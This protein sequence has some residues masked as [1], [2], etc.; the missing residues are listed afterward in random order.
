MDLRLLDHVIVIKVSLSKLFFVW[1]IKC[2]SNKITVSWQKWTQEMVRGCYNLIRQ[3][4]PQRCRG[5]VLDA[6]MPGN[7]HAKRCCRKGF[8]SSQDMFPNKH[9]ENW[10]CLQYLY[11]KSLASL[12]FNCLF[13]LKQI[14]FF[15]IDF[16][17]PFCIATI[18]F[19]FHKTN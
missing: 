12:I 4:M 6:A 8:K 16:F 1:W 10:Y 15:E 17:F 9:A 13:F 14:L 18:A 5:E 11:I 19:S 3:S 2:K 7:C